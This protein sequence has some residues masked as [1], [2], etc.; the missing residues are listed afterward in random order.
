MKISEIIKK[1]EAY[2]VNFD[3]QG[4]TYDGII[5]GDD[6]KECTGIVTTCCPTAEVIKKTTALGSN[7]IICHEPTFFDGCDRT[8]WLKNNKVYQAKK[9]LLDQTGV[10]I[11]RNHDHLHSDQPDGI[12]TGVI[13]KLGWEQYKNKEGFFPEDGYTL[14]EMR[15]KDVAAHLAK[16]LRIDGMRIIG[17]PELKVTKVVFSGHFLGNEWDNLSID[18]ID[19]DG[20]E[21]II[22]GEIIDWTIGEYVLDSIALGKKRA[23]INVGHFNWEEPGMEYMAEWLPEIIEDEVPIKFIQ[24]GNFYGWIDNTFSKK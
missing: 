21:L 14:P 5:Y 19:K 16:I 23:L 9:E 2:H 22:P 12:F 8:D 6:R 15:V 13:K 4:E 3:D 17:D 20:Y 18:G 11:Y 1:M 10:V 7:F 24:S